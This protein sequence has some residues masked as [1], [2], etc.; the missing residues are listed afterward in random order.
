MDRDA[1][2]AVS[3][4]VR[5]VSLPENTLVLRGKFP[6]KSASLR[7]WVTKLYHEALLV[8]T[9]TNKQEAIG[10]RESRRR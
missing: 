6:R 2:D 8:S 7:F 4:G 1:V 10:R 3:A 9:L 5:A